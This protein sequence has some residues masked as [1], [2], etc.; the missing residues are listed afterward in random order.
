MG[1]CVLKPLPTGFHLHHFNL[2]CLH[3]SIFVKVHPSSHSM[4]NVSVTLALLTD[5]ITPFILHN[6]STVSCKPPFFLQPV[7]CHN[8]HRIQL[9]KATRALP[10]WAL[11]KSRLHMH[12]V[13]QFF[14]L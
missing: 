1:R 7:R 2:I 11:I 6:Q 14:S 4:N 3:R 9:V 8:A 10:Y 5:T 13:T 12:L